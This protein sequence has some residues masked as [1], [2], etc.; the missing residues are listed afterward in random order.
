MP[1][2]F[3]KAETNSN[4]SLSVDKQDVRV[5]DVIT[6]SIKAE[7]ITNVF[8]IQFKL[9]YDE[10]M[11]NYIDDT[12]QSPIVKPVGNKMEKGSITYLG[13]KFGNV[14]GSSGNVT[15]ATLQFTANKEG[16]VSLAL[17]NVEAAD[18]TGKKIPTNTS[19]D[20]SFNVQKQLETPKEPVS[21]PVKEQPVVVA[22][23]P[24]APKAQTQTQA[25]VQVQTQNKV[26]EQVQTK[27]ETDTKK[28][29]D[30]KPVTGQGEVAPV[31][32]ES[33]NNNTTD[34]SIK[35][36]NPPVLVD[37]DVVSTSKSSNWK[38]AIMLGC[39]GVLTIFDI[40]IFILIS[41]RKKLSV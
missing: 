21:E 23:A 18:N 16:K 9:N 8:G 32:S 3:A 1:T 10:V 14:A 33:V 29:E 4:I 34:N 12:L 30:S 25:Q 39:I 27:I 15:L 41:K 36:D 17:S 13:S 6:V 5:N 24:E 11:L 38:S 37:K 26:Q 19:A 40:L 28:A 35:N 2:I 22:P 31:Q 20:F 7:N